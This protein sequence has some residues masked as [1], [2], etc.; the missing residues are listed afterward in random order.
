MSRRPGKDGVGVVGIGV[1]A[2][3]A[4]CAGPILGFVAATGLYTVAGV[5]AVGA[6]GLLV[7]VP[8]G[9]WWHRRRRRAAACAA[10]DEP[11]PVEIGRRP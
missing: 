1:A 6:A 9:V 7:L 11:V 8:A 4:C 5:A 3:A 2:C 10:A